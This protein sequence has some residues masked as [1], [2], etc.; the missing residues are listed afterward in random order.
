VP[1]RRWSWRPS[2]CGTSL[3]R[4]RGLATA[5][6]GGSGRRWGEP[7]GHYFRC[8]WPAVYEVRRKVII[9][10]VPLRP[11]QHFTY[12]VRAEDGTFLREITIGPF[13]PVADR[14]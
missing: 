4:E 2:I 14:G 1:V 12:D 5:P 6:S 3:I 11:I 8:P 9:G 13:A 7:L 10:G